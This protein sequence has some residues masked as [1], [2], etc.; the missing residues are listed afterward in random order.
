[1]RDKLT[2]LNV[3]IFRILNAVASLFYRKSLLRTRKRKKKNMETCNV[4]NLLQPCMVRNY[5]LVVILITRKL[6]VSKLSSLSESGLNSMSKDIAYAL[7]TESGCKSH[8]CLS[9]A[10]FF[11]LFTGCT[12]EFLNFLQQPNSSHSL[13]FGCQKNGGRSK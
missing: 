11:G 3:K 1:M 4:H 9:S 6:P 12:D 8:S 7:S 13:S 2:G 5:Y 10:Y